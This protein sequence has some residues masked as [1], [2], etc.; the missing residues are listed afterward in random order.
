MKW[1]VRMSAQTSTKSSNQNW[2]YASTTPKVAQQG[3]YLD[4]LTRNGSL[5]RIWV[6]QQQIHSYTRKEIGDLHVAGAKILF[7]DHYTAFLHPPQGMVELIEQLRLNPDVFDA[8]VVGFRVIECSETKSLVAYPNFRAHGN[9]SPTHSWNSIKSSASRLKTSM[10]QLY[11]DKKAD[12]LVCLELTYPKEVSNRLYDDFEGTIE[13]ANRCLKRFETLL[14][15]R[16]FGGGKISF[17]S[18]THPWSSNE[19][20]KPHLHHHVNF[21][22][23][24]LGAYDKKP[25]RFWPWVSKNKKV[26]ERQAFRI[27]TLWAECLWETF[28]VRVGLEGANI[29]I[30]AIPLGSGAQLYDR[31]KYCARKPVADFFEYF[32]KG[33]VVPELKAKEKAF[34]LNV[35]SYPNSRAHRGLN[36]A[37]LLV[38]PLPPAGPRCPICGAPARVIERGLPADSLEY[39]S[40]E[41]YAYVVWSKPRWLLI[42]LGYPPPGS[43]LRKLEVVA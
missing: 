41:G 5:P 3:V 33:G 7:V 30:H 10:A 28:H 8:D 22:N 20:F 31:L 40:K 11:H 36:P 39:F 1:L 2:P 32:G 4:I 21:P 26:F 43:A 37:T 34:V 12:N 15:G 6:E 13:K 29:F 24:V 17:H 27:R 23:V 42:H 35:L 14:S 9:Y 16:F 25:K 19:P 38:N 18:N